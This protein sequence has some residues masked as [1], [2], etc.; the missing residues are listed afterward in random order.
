MNSELKQKLIKLG[1]TGS[2]IDIVLVNW[3]E[4]QTWAGCFCIDSIE[5]IAL[6]DWQEHLI[7]NGFLSIGSCP[8]GD[9]VAIQIENEK[10]LPIVFISHEHEG[11]YGEGPPVWI[12]V[13]SSLSEFLIESDKDENYPADYFEMKER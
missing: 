2:F 9:L 3:P 8:N 11:L 13:S 1:L 10:D 6:F 7:H 5:D 12:K 4:K